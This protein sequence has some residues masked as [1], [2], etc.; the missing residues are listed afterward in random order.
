[1]KKK[2]KRIE[3]LNVYSKGFVV[4]SINNNYKTEDIQIKRQNQLLSNKKDKI[5]KYSLLNTN[6]VKNFYYEKIS[7]SPKK[8]NK[9]YYYVDLNELINDSND[10]TDKK[11]NNK[12]QNKKE[13]K[14]EK[15]KNTI[16]INFINIEQ[17]IIVKKPEVKKE[18]KNKKK[19]LKNDIS[20]PLMNYLNIQIKKSNKIFKKPLIKKKYNISKSADKNIE[21]INKINETEN[22]TDIKSNNKNLNLYQFMNNKNIKKNLKKNY[23]ENKKG[24]NKEKNKEMEEKGDYTFDDESMFSE[25]KYIDYFDELFNTSNITNNNIIL[26]NKNKKSGLNTFLNGAIKTKDFKNRKAEEIKQIMNTIKK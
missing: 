4:E 9:K 23:K 1:M 7:S 14:K 17:N 13:I 5:N 24:F 26:G 22:K 20:S 25:I 6:Y 18:I 2:I 12:K 15:N 16:N 8:D 19:E 21:E 10:N 3:W 11:E